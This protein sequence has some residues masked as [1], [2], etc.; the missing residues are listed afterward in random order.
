MIKHS[1]H[2]VD[3]DGDVDLLDLDEDAVSKHLV[4]L[5]TQRKSYKTYC[6]RRA[7]EIANEIGVRERGSF[8][9][10]PPPPPRFE[11]KRKTTFLARKREGDHA[12]EKSWVVN[13]TVCGSFPQ[14]R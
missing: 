10:P 5:Q 4:R 7:K 1:L 2:D 3:R 8:G 12:T 6:P 14:S 13:T 9:S 11:E